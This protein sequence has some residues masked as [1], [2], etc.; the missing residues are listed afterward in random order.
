MNKLILSSA[1]ILL[2]ASCKKISPVKEN[3]VVKTV[4]FTVYQ[5]AD[6]SGPV[7]NGVQAEVRLTISK[8]FANNSHVI[9]WDTLMPYQN[10]QAY[11]STQTPLRITKQ[12][13][14]LQNT[15]QLRFGKVIRY[16]DALNQ[17]SLVATGED[18]PS[19]VH[20][21]SVQVDL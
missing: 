20:T 15:E 3:P 2:I 17:V 8:Q 14:I 7:Y 12:F 21:K 11:P 18:I 10:L 6:Y 4:E 19:A 13:S 9:L 16:K 1:L 5:A